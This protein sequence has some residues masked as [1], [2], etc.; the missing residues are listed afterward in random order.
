MPASP[1]KGPGSTPY[2]HLTESPEAKESPKK[3]KKKE[4]EAANRLKTSP[5]PKL[6]PASNAPQLSANAPADDT[7]E[8]TQIESRAP[9][10]QSQFSLASTTPTLTPSPPLPSTGSLHHQDKKNWIK[11]DD[12]ETKP[13]W[14]MKAIFERQVP[15]E[16]GSINVKYLTELERKEFQKS[17]KVPD[18]LPTV[19]VGHPPDDSSSDSP[20]SLET[21][22]PRFAK[23]ADTLKDVADRHGPDEPTEEI[24][25]QIDYGNQSDVVY[26]A[27][28]SADSSRLGDGESVANLLIEQ[29]GVESENDT[30]APD[31]HSRLE[32]SGPS[33]ASFLVPVGYNRSRGVPTPTVSRYSEKIP[34]VTVGSGVVTIGPNLLKD[35]GLSSSN[36]RFTT[37]KFQLNDQLLFQAFYKAPIEVRERMMEAMSAVK[38]NIRFKDNMVPSNLWKRIKNKIDGKFEAGKLFVAADVAF[39]LRMSHHKDR[40][41]VFGAAISAARPAAIDKL[42]AITKTSR[43]LTSGVLLDATLEIA[44]VV[45]LETPKHAQASLDAAGDLVCAYISASDADKTIA[46]DGKILAEIINTAAGQKTSDL[47]LRGVLVGIYIAGAYKFSVSVTKHDKDSIERYKQ[48]NNLLWDSLNSVTFPGV[49]AVTAILKTTSETLITA[50]FVPRDFRT[51]L[52]QQLGAIKWAI[53]KEFENSIKTDDVL[54]GERFLNGRVME[55][56]DIAMTCNGIL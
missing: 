52:V 46:R 51:Q 14:L 47:R 44:E 38:I 4:D 26:T 31:S 5:K 7:M 12:L 10:T 27:N 16:N 6:P 19:M 55:W 24:E 37:V 34:N 30:L 9:R 23:S 2:P 11:L 17:E 43:F 20:R 32:E 50:A 42:L 22:S 33:T 48:F 39:M 54:E 45:A 49:A 35:L 18:D 41:R 1:P 28:P 53:E 36:K 15:I 8:Q 40:G 29:Y 25:T 3:G 56:I 21:Y 13:I